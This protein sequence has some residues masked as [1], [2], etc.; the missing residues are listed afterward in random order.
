MQTLLQ[1]PKDQILQIISG[2]FDNVKGHQEDSLSWEKLGEAMVLL[3]GK[4]F[5]V[6]HTLSVC[7]GD[8]LDHVQL[9]KLCMTMA[10]MEFG[11]N[12]IWMLCAALLS[13][14]VNRRASLLA[15]VHAT[16]CRQDQ[17]L[18]K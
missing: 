1:F 17:I 12:L 8:E 2:I 6:R 18:T 3:F 15:C 16:V 5:S 9:K 13:R 4:P 7:T 11:S 10:Y 14:D